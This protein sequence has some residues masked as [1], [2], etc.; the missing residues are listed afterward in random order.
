RMAADGLPVA[1]LETR[2]FLVDLD[3]PWHILEAAGKLLADLS[4]RFEGNSIAEGARVAESAEIQGSLHL[5]PG[6]VI[7]ERVVVQGDLWLG[8]EI[9]RASCRERGGISGGAGVAWCSYGG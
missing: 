1:A 2:G 9:G 3:K 8:P 5:E 4:A 7:G 6:A